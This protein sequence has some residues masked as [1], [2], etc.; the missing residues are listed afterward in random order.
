MKRKLITAVLTA[1]MI[2]TVFSGCVEQET[3]VKEEKTE[4]K[5]E[6]ETKEKTKKNVGSDILNKTDH[7][8]I[9]LQPIPGYLPMTVLQDKGW[10]EEALAE[11]GFENVEVT[12]TEF[13]SG[14]SE[15]Q[16]FNY[17]S[18]DVAVMGNVPTIT[19]A[20]ANGHRVII[21]VA[22]NGEKT[23]AV[24]VSSN[25]GISSVQELKGKRIGLVKGSIA[26]D[27]LAR[28]SKKEGIGQEDAT[29]IDTELSQQL[30]ALSSGKVDAI[31]TWQPNIAK[32]EAQGVGRVLVD[33]TGVY[34]CE[35]L[36]SANKEYADLNPD[37]VRIFLEQYK[38]ACEEVS[39]NL[40]KY[41]S[42]YASK[43][44]LSADIVL[45]TL[46]DMNFQVVINEDD[47]EDFQHTAD[48]LYVSGALSEELDIH[49]IVDTSFV[50]TLK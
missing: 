21:G 45:S 13:E 49:D 15:N 41:A 50:D 27:Y 14:P 22:Y 44:G 17:G 11:A 36:M 40:D 42:E 37:I 43:Y 33:A 20:A 30:D 48:W 4:T 12:F 9:A 5:E 46:E 2:L 39:K 19:G 34:K 8:N 25:S 38:R 18:I 6:T 47:I 16:A 23:E 3:P 32:A 31:A 26:E 24:L 29:L 1:T 35:N 10:L 7:L 28:L